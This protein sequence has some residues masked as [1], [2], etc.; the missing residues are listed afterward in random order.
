M[1]LTPDRVAEAFGL[2][3]NQAFYAAQAL[4]LALGLLQAALILGVGWVLS[5]WARRL[6]LQTIE[7]RQLD[8]ALGRFLSSILQWTVIAASV[9]A[10]LEAVGFE[11]TSLLAVF[12]SAGIAVGLALQGSLSNF[13]SGVMLLVFRPFDIGDVVTIA[14]NTGAVQEIGLFATVL[15]TADGQK[16]IVPNSGVTGATIVNVTTR[17]TRR[18]DVA[19]GVAYGADPVR[20]AEILTRAARSCELVLAEPEV[21]VGFVGLGA[22]SIDFSVMAW[23]RSA[24]FQAASWQV[25]QACYRALAEAGIEIPFPQV[26]MHQ[27]RG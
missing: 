9:L 16:V 18:T 21:T 26:V 20:V 6:A 13:A 17:G 4:N 22:S 7:A 11:T 5:K 27:A 23:C 8:L 10:S 3:A 19:V 15:F 1:N 24:E 12:A 2:S 14:G 25:R